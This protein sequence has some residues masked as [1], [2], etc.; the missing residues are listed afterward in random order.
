[1]LLCRGGWRAAVA[2]GVAF[3][4]GLWISL[5]IMPCLLVTLGA[6][7]LFASWRG[8][9]ALRNAAVF[10]ASLAATTAAVLPAALPPTLWHD[11]AISWFSP[12]TVLFATLAGAVFILGW[13]IGWHTQNRA[14]RL[15]LMAALASL[16]MLL[17]LPS[18]RRRSRDRLPITI[19]SMP[20][21]RSTTSTKRGRCWVNFAVFPPRA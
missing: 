2:A 21:S 14:L 18:C 3:A 7:G 6:L 8:G 20:A 1:M 11:F 4:C 9:F 19:P 12:A 16:A 17:S 10:G 5:E 15:A 13:L